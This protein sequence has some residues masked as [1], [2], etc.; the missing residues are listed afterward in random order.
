MTVRKYAALTQADHEDQEHMRI[1]ENSRLRQWLGCLNNFGLKFTAIV[2]AFL[3]GYGTFRLFGDLTGSLNRSKVVSDPRFY[4]KHSCGRSASEGISNGC[5]FDWMTLDYRRPD[6]IDIELSEEFSRLGTG[7]DGSWEFLTA[8][9]GRESEYALV[10]ESML[11]NLVE[12]GRQVWTSQYWHVMFCIYKW[13]AQYRG[14]FLGTVDDMDRK[15]A[16]LHHGHCTH[17][18]K[19][20]VGDLDD[21][22]PGIFEYHLRKLY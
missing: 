9:P 21:F 13:R 1:P 17:V 14:Q 7:P 5:M 16:E 11:A 3:A 6:C 4:C 19:K 15:G 18:I 2:V 10:N 12:P 8:M 20:Y 22:E